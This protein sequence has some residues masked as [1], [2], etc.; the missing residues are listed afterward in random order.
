MKAS[1][2]L[3]AIIEILLCFKKKE[4]KKIIVAWLPQWRSKQTNY[5]CFLLLLIMK[6]YL[7]IVYNGTVI[8]YY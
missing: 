4:E 7:F 2:K 1:E 5:V 8:G 6:F 3:V